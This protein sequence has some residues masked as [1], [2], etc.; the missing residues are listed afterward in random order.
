MKKNLIAF[1]SVVYLFCSVF[2]SI[3]YAQ[4]AATKKPIEKT[5][6]SAPSYNS[7]KIT[8]NKQAED[9]KKI[10]SDVV[11]GSAT[12]RRINHQA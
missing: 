3:A 11:D 4:D 1:L 10:V 7:K 8:D 12:E 6:K 2:A 5:Q 9:N